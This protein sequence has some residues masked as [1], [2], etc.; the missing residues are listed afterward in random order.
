MRVLCDL[1]TCRPRPQTP[2][3]CRGSINVLEGSSGPSV[4]CSEAIIAGILAVTPGVVITA[5]A[6]NIDPSLGSNTI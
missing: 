1:I 6:R 4:E 3:G 2:Y 5:R